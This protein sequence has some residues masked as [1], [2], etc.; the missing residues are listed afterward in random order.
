MSVHLS[1]NRRCCEECRES[2]NQSQKVLEKT[3]GWFRG[4]WGGNVNSIGAGGDERMRDENAL[5]MK[6]IVERREKW[7]RDVEEQEA[8]I[9]R[10][11]VERLRESVRSDLGFEHEAMK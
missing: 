11:R 7:I 6:T 9:A 2:Q 3:G 8:R 10:R 1:I 5:P 4:K